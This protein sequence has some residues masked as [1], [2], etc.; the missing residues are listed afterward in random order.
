MSNNAF[1]RGRLVTELDTIFDGVPNA[2]FYRARNRRFEV[3][4]ANAVSVYTDQ[5]IARY[6][7]EVINIERA[8]I[9]QLE[10]RVANLERRVTTLEQRISR[11]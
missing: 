6:D 11:R 8:R 9:T 5:R 1:L 2:A 7:S 10:Q 3:A 4:V